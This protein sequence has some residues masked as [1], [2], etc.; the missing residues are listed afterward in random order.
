M[1]AL[2]SSTFAVTGWV[3]TEVC[4]AWLPLFKR[5]LPVPAKPDGRS[6]RRHVQ[7]VLREKGLPVARVLW[8]CAE[9]DRDIVWFINDPG[10]RMTVELRAVRNKR[11]LDWD[12]VSWHNLSKWFDVVVNEP[13]IGLL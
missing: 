9:T 1:L 7:R 2:H 10:P 3:W 5:A 6:V 12:K 8:V 11:A 4:A 13:A